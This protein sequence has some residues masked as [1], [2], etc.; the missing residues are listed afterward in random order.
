MPNAIDAAS[1]ANRALLVNLSISRWRSAKS[2]KK[3][4]HEVAATH[5]NEEN[6]GNY[7]KSLLARG[8][9]QSG[10]RDRHQHAKNITELLF[11][12]AKRGNRVLTS[13]AYFDYANF[14]PA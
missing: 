1:L 2:D 8:S 11:H 9:T 10:E 13:A 14:A 4:N 3:V 5:G 7:R 6:M 12:G